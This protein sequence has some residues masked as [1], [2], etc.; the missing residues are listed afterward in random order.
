MNPLI[1]RNLTHVYGNDETN[2]AAVV[3]V[4][5]EFRAGETCVLMGPSGSGKT[6]LFSIFG[7]LL[8]PTQGELHVC[9]VPVHAA[10]PAKRTER[11]RTAIG[12]VFQHSHL[13]P[14][15]SLEDNLLAIG[16][17][18]GV[19][20]NE[21][22]KRVD[23]LLDRLDVAG[24]RHR[25]P[26]EVSGGQ[27]QRF[28]IPRALLHTP[29]IVL[30]DEPTAALGWRHGEEAVRLLIDEARSVGALLIAVTHDA[31]LAPLFDRELK[32]E[33]GRIRQSD[34]RGEGRPG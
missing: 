25:R 3:G 11:R 10:P 4:A 34:D 15:L 16:R 7:C 29:K 30:A 6:T 23:G 13:L 9:G 27:R 24:L 19:P 26:H 31:R 5:A 28:A 22:R 33:N 8:A 12:F 17:N 1:C 20:Q 14:F 32:I 21:L 18:A 2:E